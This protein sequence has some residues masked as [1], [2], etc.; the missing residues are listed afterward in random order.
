MKKKARLLGALVVASLVSLSLVG[1]GQIK[2]ET[3]VQQFEIVKTVHE[4]ATASSGVGINAQSGGVTVGGI[5][6]TTGQYAPLSVPIDN[7]T[8][9]RFLVYL[10]HKGKTYKIDSKTIYDQAVAGQ[11]EFQLNLTR[12]YLG[13]ELW[14]E[15]VSP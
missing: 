13:E 1:C 5:D 6:M 4:D 14:D 7:G 9:E 3:S 10:K 11:R 2:R 12:V 15:Y 8:P